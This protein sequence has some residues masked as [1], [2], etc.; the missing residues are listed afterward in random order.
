MNLLEQITNGQNGIWSERWRLATLSR[1]ALVKIG[2]VSIMLGLIFAMFHLQG[3]TTEIRQEFGRSAIM[4]MVFRWSDSGVA[5]GSGTDY[6]HGFLIPI[7]SAAI[8][9]Y[10]REEI[11]RAAKSLS[12]MGLAVVVLGLLMHWM[13]AK[14]QQT[15]LSLMALIFLIWGIPYYLHGWNVAKILMFPCSYL[16]FCIPLNFLDSLTFPLRIS[17]AT[18]TCWILN[19]MGIAAQRS[20][21]AI[22]SMAAGGFNFDVADP[23]SGLRSLLALTALTAIYAYLTQ[24]T[25]LKKWILFLSAIP[26][27]IIGN[28]FRITTVAL[29]GEAFGQK[30][31]LQLY[32]DFAGYVIFM[33]ITIPLMMAFGGFLNMNFSEVFGR[34]KKTLLNPISS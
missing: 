3:N 18:I 8:V 29:V 16:I 27:A 10:K 12:R 21:S 22:Y 30:V 9:W 4:W 7:A 25:V 17:M 11:A 6:S 20:G 5:F 34:W 28:I 32:H 15:R 1:E 26:L 24:R 31:A 13:G 2:L 23:C 19:G 14:T 33:I